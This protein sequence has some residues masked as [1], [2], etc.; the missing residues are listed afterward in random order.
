VERDGSSVAST[1]SSEALTG[2]LGWVLASV[3]STLAEASTSLSAGDI[4]IT[5]SAVPPIEV[6]GGSWT[7]TAPGLGEVG[8][9]LG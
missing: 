4:V 9:R 2:E 8:V 7:V 5:G 3:A 1:S 6:S